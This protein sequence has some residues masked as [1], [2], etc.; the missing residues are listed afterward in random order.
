MRCRNVLAHPPRDRMDW[1]CCCLSYT[2][3]LLVSILIVWIL[4]SY[5]LCFALPMYQRG[6]VVP[7]VLCGA[8]C[9]FLMM[10]MVVAFLRATFTAPGYVRSGWEKDASLHLLEDA[11]SDAEAVAVSS[12]VGAKSDK[13]GLR[14]PLAN[15]EPRSHLPVFE[16]KSTTGALRFCRKCNVYKPDRAHHCS[17]CNRCVLKMDHHCPWINN[18]VGFANQ[19]FFLLFLSY[20]PV[21]A[22]WIVASVAY[23]LMHGLDLTARPMDL[24]NLMAS[25]LVAGTF[26]VSLLLFAGFHCRLVC[27]NRTTIE[28]FEKATN[29]LWDRGTRDNFQQVF[30]THWL[31][32]ILPVP[33]T[34][35]N[36]I[37]FPAGI[38][39]EA[40]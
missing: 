23:Y 9:L 36:G 27:G 30:G 38:Q 31:W 7:A 1:C 19:K 13:V 33:S 32:A 26:G 15:N 5:E 14:H 22:A 40:P 3:V 29:S 11:E 20:I 28:T 24:V 10:L 8:T 4:L 25:V 6:M 37:I 34:P 16:Y 12:G 21:C 17:D 18:C 39:W 35:G 2:P